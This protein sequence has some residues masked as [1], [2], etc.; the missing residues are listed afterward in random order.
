MYA[1]AFELNGK[2]SFIAFGDKIFTYP[3]IALAAIDFRGIED[4]AHLY[5]IDVDLSTARIEKRGSLPGA[6]DE[7][8]PTD[9]QKRLLYQSYVYKSLLEWVPD[10]EENM[11][12]V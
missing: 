4:Q 9:N 1:F 3:S 11:S 10:A 5:R 12:Q 8:K 2:M 7:F 6:P